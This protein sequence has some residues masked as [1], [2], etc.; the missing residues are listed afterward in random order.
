M[1]VTGVAVDWD[2]IAPPRPKATPKHRNLRISHYRSLS[3][4]TT[5][6]QP[7]VPPT[8]L[9]A[10]LKIVVSPVQ[11]WVSP[12]AGFGLVMRFSGG[13]GGGSEG[14]VRACFA[15]HVLFTSQW[16]SRLRRRAAAELRHGCSRAEASASAGR[17]SAVALDEQQARTTM[18]VALSGLV[19]GGAMDGI[20]RPLGRQAQMR[21]P[22]QPIAGVWLPRSLDRDL[23]LRRKWDCDGE[24]GEAVG[25]VH[26][27]K[28]VPA[29][30]EFAAHVM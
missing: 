18:S 4:K 23:L 3:L 21:R 7:F 5:G 13:R 24:V 22:G 1:S 27:A 16:G 2:L 14:L 17:P 10:S 28:Q 26:E 30:E 20:L 6:L 11:I 8:R 29:C 12:S 25:R 19:Q 9:Y 15:R